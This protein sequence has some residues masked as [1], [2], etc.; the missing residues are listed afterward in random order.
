MHFPPLDRMLRPEE[1]RQALEQAGRAGLTRLEQRDL[2]ALVRA[3]GV[4]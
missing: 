2:A 1:Y 3:L 4:V